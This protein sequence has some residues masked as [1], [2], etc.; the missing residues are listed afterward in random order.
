MSIVSFGSPFVSTLLAIRLITGDSTSS[1]G[2]FRG[3]NHQNLMQLS[4]LIN[5]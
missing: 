3:S 2:A 1:M 4:F 5:S